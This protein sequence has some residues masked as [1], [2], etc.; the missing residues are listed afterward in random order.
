MNEEEF[1]AL[2]RQRYQQIKDLQTVE[3]FYDYEKA[4]DN[5]WTELGN[6][7]LQQSISHA[8]TDRRKKK[9]SSPATE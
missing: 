2:A 3:S 6:Q 4:F 1:V 8:P 9:D 7:V 5:L